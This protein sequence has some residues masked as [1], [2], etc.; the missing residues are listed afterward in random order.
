M[1]I[2]C[3]GCNKIIKIIR[4]LLKIKKNKECKR[5]ENLQETKI[6]LYIVSI[7]V[8][9]LKGFKKCIE[10]D[11]LNEMN[12]FQN[13]NEKQNKSNF[14]IKKNIL[15]YPQYFQ[16]NN[17]ILYSIMI[18]I[19]SIILLCQCNKDKILF[20]FSEITLKVKGNGN[21]IIL[22]DNFYQSY[23][24]SKIY[25]IDSLENIATNKY[26]FNNSEIHT[27]RIEW[28]TIINNTNEMFMDCNKI[29][30]IDLTNFNTV[31]VRNMSYMLFN[32]AS[33]ISIN[34][35]NFDT[36]KVNNLDRIF[37]NCSSLISLDLSNFKTS[38]VKNMNRMFALC[39]SL[40]KLNISNFDTSE[41]INM[42][43]MFYNCSLLS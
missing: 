22:S 40:N 11:D 1:S 10:Q 38:K 43:Y 16:Q 5:R 39:S 25:I 32:C 12:I 27:L 42:K 20:N 18:F 3:E 29:I 4:K 6:N 36:S 2:C 23:K 33:L 37:Y 24:P 35:S 7:T 31:N 8:K 17:I 26:Y 14:L 34:L 30:N 28:N 9:F 19:N 21:I 13:N 15:K 41:V